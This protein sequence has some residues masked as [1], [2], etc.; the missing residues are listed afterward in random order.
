MKH[1]FI[2][3]L[4]FIHTFCKNVQDSD[5]EYSNE[6]RLRRNNDDSD[7]ENF[8]PKAP[9]RKRIHNADEET[10]YEESS[11]SSN[12][13][14]RNNDASFEECD[15][16]TVKSNCKSRLHGDCCS[17]CKVLGLR[18]VGQSVSLKNLQY[19]YLKLEMWHYFTHPLSEWSQPRLHLSWPLL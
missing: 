4:F 8:K 1:L 7:E 5:H 17:Q 12:I 6:I 3:L 11:E 19:L 13:N 9:R 2:L 16:T 10:S 14:H 18:S 15:C